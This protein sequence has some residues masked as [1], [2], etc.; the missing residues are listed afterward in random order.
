MGNG[1][2][3]RQ[4]ILDAALTLFAKRGYHGTSVPS[5]AELAGVGAGTIYRY[6][7]SKEALANVL[8]QEWKGQLGAYILEGFPRDASFRNQFRTWFERQID[9]IQRHPEASA[10]MELHHHASYLDEA[11][12]A[13]EELHVAVGTEIIEL[14]QSQEALREGPPILLLA[15]I[16]GAVVGL[17]RASWE[18]RI[19]LTP[20]VLESAEQASWELVRA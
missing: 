8:Y 5:V 19:E 17:V 3:R 18:G 16:Y 10:F 7:E 4:A 11:S 13:L 20:E 12:L 15:L 6:F 1:V 9:F 2:D 14:G